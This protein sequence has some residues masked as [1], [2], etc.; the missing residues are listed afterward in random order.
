[1]CGG[2]ERQQKR[3]AIIITNEKNDKGERKNMIFVYPVWSNK[4]L[5]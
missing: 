5:L 3:I 1:M 4:D 2:K